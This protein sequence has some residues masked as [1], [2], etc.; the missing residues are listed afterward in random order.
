MAHGAEINSRNKDGSTPLELA[1]A[2]GHGKK[3]I[4]LLIR[5]GA[6]I[7]MLDLVDRTPLH[8]A[9]MYG[10]AEAVMV[11]LGHNVALNRVETEGCTPSPSCGKKRSQHACRPPP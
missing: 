3:F 8:Y 11:L 7:A 1:I 5:E 2:Y 10:N 6:D 4:K 9:A